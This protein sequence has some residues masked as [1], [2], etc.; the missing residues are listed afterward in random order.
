M[1]SADRSTW[2]EADWRNIALYGFCTGCGAPRESSTGVDDDGTPFV[3]RRCS[4]PQHLPG[5]IQRR[6][7]VAMGMWEAIHGD[8]PDPA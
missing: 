5:T 2:T 1:A 6:W 8:L 3:D 4:N 7:D